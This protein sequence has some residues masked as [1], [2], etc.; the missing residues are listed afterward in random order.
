MDHQVEHRGDIA[1][2][3]R[4]RPVAQR[5]QAERLL[6]HIQQAHGLEHHPLLVPAGHDQALGGG[7]RAHP[8][9]VSDRGRDGL[10]DIDVPARGQGRQGVFGVEG[11]GRGHRNHV[12]RRQELGHV[13]EPS[14]AQGHGDLGRPVG[15]G[16]QHAGQ[17]GA[18][19][20]GVLAR[21]IA[22]EHARADDAAPDG[23]R[24]LP[25]SPLD[26]FETRPAAYQVMALDATRAHAPAALARWRGTS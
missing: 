17:H 13:G 7:R 15:M 16:I 14:A 23:F 3:V 4:R 18:G 6:R 11:R 10:F 9:A 2:A 24:H 5:L 20:R 26:R 25:D 1:A 12:H 21:M 22:A 19:Q 8:L